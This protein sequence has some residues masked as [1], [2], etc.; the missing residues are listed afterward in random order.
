MNDANGYNIVPDNS[1]LSPVCGRVDFRLVSISVVRLTLARAGING[2][3]KGGQGNV[4]RLG[5]RQLL[6]NSIICATLSYEMI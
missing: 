6:E 2:A 4:P 3:K 5:T 1:F